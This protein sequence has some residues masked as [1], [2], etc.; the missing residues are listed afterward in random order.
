MFETLRRLQGGGI[1]RHPAALFSSVVLEIGSMDMDEAQR[2]CR[3]D[4]GFSDGSFCTIATWQ[5]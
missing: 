4:H 3:R 1:S 5:G 2:P